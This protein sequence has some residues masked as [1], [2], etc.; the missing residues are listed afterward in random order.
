MSDL[1]HIEKIS[2][3]GYLSKFIRVLELFIHLFIASTF[4]I[5]PFKV[6]TQKRSQLQCGKKVGFQMT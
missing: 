6:A 3:Y 5:A 2:Q 4:Y 1:C